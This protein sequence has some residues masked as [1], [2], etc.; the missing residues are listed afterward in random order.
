MWSKASSTEKPHS[1]PKHWP[2]PNEEDLLERSQR[3][4]AIGEEQSYSFCNNFVK[5]SKYE[6]YNFIP[7]F[8]LEE[9]N[10]KTK[11]ANCYFLLIAALQCFRPISNTNGI[12]TTLV[13]LLGVVAVDGLFQVLEDISRHKAGNPNSN[14]RP[15][16]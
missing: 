3:V 2:K 16:S 6:M 13:P 9:F 11:V 1:L 4:I 14:S 8:L 5:T 7:K 10:P 15:N 12:P